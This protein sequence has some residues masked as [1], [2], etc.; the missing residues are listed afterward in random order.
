M[1]MMPYCSK[2]LLRHARLFVELTPLLTYPRYS[3]LI[4]HF[5]QYLLVRCLYRYCCLI[6]FSPPLADTKLVTEPLPD[7]VKHLHPP[8]SVHLGYV[9]RQNLQP[10]YV[11][12]PSLT[13]V[14]IDCVGVWHHVLLEILLLCQDNE[15]MMKKKIHQVEVVVDR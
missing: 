9:S 1:V 14:P 6:S 13:T 3:R 2:T 5:H 7:L 10:I 12:M 8:N 15:S 4:D 11:V